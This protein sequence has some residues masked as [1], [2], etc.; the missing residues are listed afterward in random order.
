MKVGII[1]GTGGMGE[2]FALRWCANHE[3]ILGS[4]DKQ[5][6]QT[7]SENHMNNIKNSRYV[8]KVKGTIRGSDN[9]SVAKESDI[10][11]LSIPYE[12]IQSTCNGN[13]KHY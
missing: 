8:D 3:I 12:N 6:A 4:R 7:V 9:L 11:I 2:G 10:L 5:K 13:S 1:G